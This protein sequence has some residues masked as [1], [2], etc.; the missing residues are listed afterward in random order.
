MVTGEY[1][2]NAIPRIN[3]LPIYFLGISALAEVP[4]GVTGL[5]RK[6]SISVSSKLFLLF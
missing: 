4:N 5:S 6:L 1:K 2:I 3:P